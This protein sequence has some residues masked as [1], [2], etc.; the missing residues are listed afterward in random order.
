M[1]GY[2]S[3]PKAHAELLE[4]VDY[5]ARKSG[6]ERAHA[7]LDALLKAAELI[8]E[9]PSIG[10]L[11]EDL[12]DEPVRFWPVYS[13]LLIYRPETRPVEFIHVVSGSRHIAAL[14]KRKA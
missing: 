14:L 2:R 11:R 12:V 8:A 13:Y 5:I 6:P 10:H 3:T 1:S 7:V 4:I 9:Y